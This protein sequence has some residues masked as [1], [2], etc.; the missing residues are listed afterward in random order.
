MSQTKKFKKLKSDAPKVPKQS[1]V[2]RDG[3]I[4]PQ[5]LNQFNTETVDALKT[6]EEWYDMGFSIVKSGGLEYMNYWKGI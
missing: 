4:N 3:V 1:K 6:H 5:N 2:N